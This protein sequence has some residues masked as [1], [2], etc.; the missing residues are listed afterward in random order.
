M[1]KLFKIQGN[2]L[3]PSFEDG[4]RVLCVKTFQFLK[5]KINDFIVFEKKG[6]GLMV[7]QIISIEDKGYFVKGYDSYSIDSRDF[8][9]LSKSEIKY[10]V[11]KKLL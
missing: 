9:L 11:L 5:L 6:Y 2:S 1:L 8:G 3:Y 10:K 7:K 4:Q